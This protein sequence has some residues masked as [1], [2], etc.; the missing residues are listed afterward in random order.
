MQQNKTTSDDTRLRLIN[1]AGDEFASSGYQ[2]AN[3]RKICEAAGAN[4]SAVKYHF[5]SKKDLYIAVWEVASAQMMKADP[6]PQLGDSDNPRED[7]RQLI[8]WFMKL[9]LTKSESHPWAGQL[10]AHETVSPTPGVLDVFV[11]R[12][13]GPINDEMSRIIKAIVGRP[14]RGKTHK[15]LVFAVVALCVNAKHCHEILTRLGHPPPESKAGIVRMATV[16]ADFA[17]SGLDGF[18][19]QE[20]E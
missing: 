17:I 5:G 19:E 15:D 2:A 11:S 12:C 10:L 8:C 6:M 16:M 9:V 1:A 4:I 18:I 13:A 3:V 14:L 7:L 20:D